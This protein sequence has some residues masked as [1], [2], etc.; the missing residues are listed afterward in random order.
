M[1]EFVYRDEGWLPSLFTKQSPSPRAVK[2]SAQAGSVS[3]CL[4]LSL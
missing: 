1:A 2:R 3:A 4:L